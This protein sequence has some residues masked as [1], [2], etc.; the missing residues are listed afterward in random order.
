[1]PAMLCNTNIEAV[2]SGLE[3]NRKRDLRL[4][5][6]LATTR[7]GIESSG[8]SIYV[9]RYAEVV[10]TVAGV[11]TDRE[12]RTASKRDTAESGIAGVVVIRIEA[13]VAPAVHGSM[14]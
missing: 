14:R 13:I 4:C 1:M 12:V 2:A 11:E 10:P 5:A 7:C 8:V 3:M 9:A 6:I